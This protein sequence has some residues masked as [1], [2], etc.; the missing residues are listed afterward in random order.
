MTANFTRLN[1]NDAKT[2]IDQGNS[3]ILDIRDTLSYKSGHIN[4]AIHIDNQSIGHF[5]EKTDSESPIIVCC[6]H[7]N[8]SQNAAH[9]LSEQ[10]FSN[11]YSLD[12]G[13]EQ[14]KVMYPDAC[15]S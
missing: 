10:G 8:S 5:I 13:Y 1:P 14:W 7:G 15:E 3:H 9:Y 6:Y 4:N 11:V 2:I 12:G